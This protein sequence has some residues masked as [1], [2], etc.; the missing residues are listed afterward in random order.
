MHIKQFS[1]YT[2]SYKSF[3][4]LFHALALK[5]APELTSFP[6]QDVW[7][8]EDKSIKI[9][10]I[11]IL[12]YFHITHDSFP[13]HSKTLAGL[14]CSLQW[15]TG[16]LLAIHRL[17]F[18]A[19]IHIMPIKNIL[20]ILFCL[21]SRSCI[22]QHWYPTKKRRNQ[23]EEKGICTWSSPLYWGVT[24]AIKKILGINIKWNP[25]ISNIEKKKKRLGKK[26]Y[27]VKCTGWKYIFLPSKKECFFYLY[28]TDNCNTLKMYLHIY[29]YIKKMIYSALIS[30]DGTASRIDLCTQ[31]KEIMEEAQSMQDVGMPGLNHRW[32]KRNPRKEWGE[33][34]R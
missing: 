8:W 23:Y 11:A 24:C 28:Q 29:R 12:Q 21:D 30:A 15:F 20:L 34:S 1:C 4:T 25:Q 7:G 33:E 22:L 32:D 26:K 19:P 10:W 14:S 3:P 16:S 31:R 13:G 17:L 27:L 9:L 6:R 18:L 2:V 5:P